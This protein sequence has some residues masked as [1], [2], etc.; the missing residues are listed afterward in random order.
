MLKLTLSEPS[1]QSV[2]VDGRNCRPP[3]H[4]F[5]ICLMV[6]HALKKI[7]NVPWDSV[8]V[9][10]GLTMGSVDTMPERREK[11]VPRSTALAARD[12]RGRLL[13]T[14]YTSPAKRSKVEFGL[15]NMGDDEA[16]EENIHR[17]EERGSTEKMPRHDKAQIPQAKEEQ[18]RQNVPPAN[19]GESGRRMR[20][21]E[22]LGSML[23]G[24]WD[25]HVDQNGGRPK[26]RPADT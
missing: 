25:A 2:M 5:R 1:R 9:F 3:K 18:E 4:S 15:S 14:T 21:V 20:E 24:A 17:P 7:L 11:S 8:D 16:L 12:K 22:K 6:S 23:G 10:G 26:R 19:K 13:D